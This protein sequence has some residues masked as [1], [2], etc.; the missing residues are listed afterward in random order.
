MKQITKDDMERMCRAAGMRPEKRMAIEDREL[1]IADGFSA[2][3]HTKFRRF[4][5][6]PGEF[7]MGCYVTIWWLGKDENLEVGLPMIFDAFHDKELGHG[8]RKQARINRAIREAG[9][10]LRRRKLNG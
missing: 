2:P 1:F 9:G 10:F 7:P 4:D 6:G 5:V 8:F 3:P